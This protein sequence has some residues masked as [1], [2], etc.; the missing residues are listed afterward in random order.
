MGRQSTKHRYKSRGDKNREVW[1][2]VRFVV[3]GLLLLLLFLAIKHGEDWW[4]Y[5]RT[6]FY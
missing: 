2:L 6:Y 4:R 5:Y 3:A 1:R